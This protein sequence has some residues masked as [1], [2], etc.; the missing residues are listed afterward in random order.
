MGEQHKQVEIYGFLTRRKRY[1]TAADIRLNGNANGRRVAGAEHAWIVLI[2]FRFDFFSTFSFGF[3]ISCSH[4][5]IGLKKKTLSAH[6]LCVFVCARN[7]L[8]V[9]N[10]LLLLVR[11]MQLSWNDKGE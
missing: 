4:I 6:S 11:E 8:C 2:L 9:V 3:S 10:L 1:V 7:E 5:R